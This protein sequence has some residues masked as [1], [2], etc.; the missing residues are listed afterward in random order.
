MFPATRE[1]PDSPGCEWTYECDIDDSLQFLLAKLSRTEL[2]T[3][4]EEEALAFLAGVFDAEGSILLHKKWEW[5]NPEIV[6]TNTD[7]QLIE[8]VEAI[9]RSLGLP[10]VDA[11]DSTEGREARSAGKESCRPN[12]GFELPRSTRHTPNF[13]PTPRGEAR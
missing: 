12:R 7:S 3:L 13:A 4:S 5:F 1:G 8:F 6:I 2:D 9:L 10:R 11:L